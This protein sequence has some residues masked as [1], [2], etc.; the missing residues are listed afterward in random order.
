MN[1]EE[2]EGRKYS[3]PQQHRAVT[4]ECKEC[5]LQTIEVLNICAFF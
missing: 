1:E 2:D 3:A 5:Q 4:Q